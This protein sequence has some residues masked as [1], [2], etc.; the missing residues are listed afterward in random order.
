MIILGILFFVCMF[1]LFV[2][3]ASVEENEREDQDE[4]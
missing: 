3:G 2:L 1:V 4:V